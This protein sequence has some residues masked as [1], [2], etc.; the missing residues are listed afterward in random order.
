LVANETKLKSQNKSRFF[1]TD[2]QLDQ[3]VV[4]R[5]TNSIMRITRTATSRYRDLRGRTE[6]SFRQ[7][8]LGFIQNSKIKRVPPD[9]Y[10]LRVLDR[11]RFFWAFEA[12][13]LTVFS[14]KTQCISVIGFAHKYRAPVFFGI[15]GKI[16]GHNI[17]I[18][19][20]LI[21]PASF[22]YMKGLY[23]P[24]DRNV[25]IAKLLAIFKRIVGDHD[26]EIPAGAGDESFFAAIPFLGEAHAFTFPVRDEQIMGQIDH[27]VAG[28]VSRLCR[29]SILETCTDVIYEFVEE[30]YHQEHE[31]AWQEFSAHASHRIGN[32]ISSVGTLLD[33]LAEQLIK[34]PK[35]EPMWKDKLSVMQGC[36]RA[37]KKMLSDLTVLT[38]QITPR[39][40]LTN[41][42][43]LLRRAALGV[44][45]EQAKI[46]L[47][48]LPP[49]T[50][51]LVDPELM[52][53][54][55]RELCTN[56]VRA[57]G[58]NLSLI[59]SEKK[60]KGTLN[61]SFQD[62]GPGIPSERAECI[63]EP[64]V[65][66]PVGR[67][68]LGLATVR[69]IIEAHG[70]SIRLQESTVGAHFVISLPLERIKQK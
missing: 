50:Q 25:L 17:G 6:W 4:S 59:I 41:F 42:R 38:A 20:D 46:D 65:V 1:I 8:I 51:L 15:P 53:Q 43:E 67:T 44:L 29:D 37:G 21:H 2:E 27:R 58:E 5:L 48:H 24:T 32:E 57:A 70:G 9:L 63:F 39:P 64:F 22:L 12:V 26:L 30:R 13:Y 18:T 28:G 35:W 55:F 11:M 7:E 33:V 40:K 10:L 19:Y 66:F 52:E 62:N 49:D 68:G 61:I 36:V 56:A 14:P 3:R 60:E 69:R 47:Q 23:L 16:V 54:A 31:R 34:D 45:P